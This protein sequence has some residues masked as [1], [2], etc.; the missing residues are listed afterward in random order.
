[1]WHDCHHNHYVYDNIC[2]SIGL[3]L[4]NSPNKVALRLSIQ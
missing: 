3:Q 2:H 4:D 1:M